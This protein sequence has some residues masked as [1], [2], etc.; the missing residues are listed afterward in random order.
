MAVPWESDF[1]RLVA[2][3]RIPPAPDTMARVIV[4]P[5]VSTVMTLPNPSRRATFVVPIVRPFRAEVDW[6]CQA[7]LVGPLTKKSSSSNSLLPRVLFSDR[8]G[9]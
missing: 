1:V 6:L 9:Q 3:V 5:P 8:A 7:R 2:E 4:D